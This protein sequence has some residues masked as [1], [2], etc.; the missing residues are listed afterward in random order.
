MRAAALMGFNLNVS[1]PNEP[2]AEVLE[3]VAALS[4]KSGSTVKLVKD[5]KEAV[6]DV[7]QA[8]AHRH[9]F[10]AIPGFVPWKSQKNTDQHEDDESQWFEK[11]Q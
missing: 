9:K 2:E 11:P 4:A 10:S 6:K 8:F 5:P 7:V 3:E 1:G